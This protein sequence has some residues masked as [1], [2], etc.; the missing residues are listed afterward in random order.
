MNVAIGSSWYLRC[1]SKIPVDWRLETCSFC[2]TSTNRHRSWAKKFPFKNTRV[3]PFYK[4]GDEE[5]CPGKMKYLDKG[6]CSYPFSHK[7]IVAQLM[8]SKSRTLLPSHALL[9]LMIFSSLVNKPESWLPGSWQ[10]PSLCYGGSVC[11]YSVL[12]L[13][14]VSAFQEPLEI[15]FF[16]Y[17]GK[18]YSTCGSG[19]LEASWASCCFRTWCCMHRTWKLSVGEKKS[20]LFQVPFEVYLFFKSAL[21]LVNLCPVNIELV[22]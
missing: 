14:Y 16:H 8:S 7:A 6:H 19:I 15:I 17:P 22:N 12:R 10:R 9:S 3:P 11:A 5:L 4:Q 20:N 2:C 21:I 13:N 18:Q 1:G